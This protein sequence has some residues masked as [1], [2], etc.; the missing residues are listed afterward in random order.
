MVMRSTIILLIASTFASS[1]E[2]EII[3]HIDRPG[4]MVQNDNTA[5]FTNFISTM[6]AFYIVNLVSPK[7][8]KTMS[9]QP[10]FEC[11][12][13]I[14][15]EKCPYSTTT[16]PADG[17]IAFTH[18]TSGLI[19]IVDPATLQTKKCFKKPDKLANQFTTIE[20]SPNGNLMACYAG[21]DL[22]MVDTHNGL[23]TASITDTDGFLLGHFSPDNLKFV[24][25]TN[26]QKNIKIRDLKNLD[27]VQLTINQITTGHSWS[28][29]LAY[30][31]HGTELAVGA[32]DRICIYDPSNGK[33]KIQWDSFGH[34]IQ[35]HPKISDTKEQYQIQHVAYN[36]IDGTLAAGNSANERCILV[37]CDPS[38]K[39]LSQRFTTFEGFNNFFSLNFNKEGTK[40]LASFG[41]WYTKLWNTIPN[42][43]HGITEHKNWTP[44]DLALLT[45]AKK[46]MVEAPAVKAWC[47]VL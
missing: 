6:D 28:N 4:H 47:D 32:N 21:Q 39:Q 18:I 16:N 38:G 24:N 40:L 11:I 42:K 33:L 22:I 41:G 44:E 3:T 30:N 45:V 27:S 15:K 5:L 13:E 9:A 37:L 12:A 36:P 34:P 26:N 10:P 1:M 17:S 2:K 7:G 19:T 8:I 43:M 25:A 35:D 20:F 31:K 23:V 14:D 46:K 29:P